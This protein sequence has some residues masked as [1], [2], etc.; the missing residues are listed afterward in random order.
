MF[1]AS[2]GAALGRA[3]II[4]PQECK[5]SIQDL[6]APALAHLLSA[7]AVTDEQQCAILWPYS[8]IIEC[9]GWGALLRPPTTNRPL[10]G[11]VVVRRL[12][13]CILS[14]QRGR[15]HSWAIALCVSLSCLGARPG[16]VRWRS[17][18]SFI[19]PFF[20][21]VCF[22]VR[23]VTM[24]MHPPPAVCPALLIYGPLGEVAG[25]CRL[26]AIVQSQRP[27]LSAAVEKPGADE[28]EADEDCDE[29]KVVIDQTRGICGIGV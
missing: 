18:S 26:S 13:A 10:R 25:Q 28:E 15:R 22:I 29:D 4:Q 20:T 3:R 7:I 1:V 23:A 17:L 27:A 14:I 11:Q 5:G 12:Q 2:L 24:A 16:L 6:Y 8:S 9:T 21:R 19:Q